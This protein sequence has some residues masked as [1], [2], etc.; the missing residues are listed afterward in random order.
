MLE[1]LQIVSGHEK[2]HSC[3]F[4]GIIAKLLQYTIW[5]LE[6]NFKVIPVNIYWQGYYGQWKV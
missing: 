4:I 6:I 1:I 3:C 2:N 5:S